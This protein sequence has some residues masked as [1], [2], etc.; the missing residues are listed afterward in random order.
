MKAN[1]LNQAFNQAQA[2]AIEKYVEASLEAL[3]PPTQ[4]IDG[5]PVVVNFAEKK[6]KPAPKAEQIPEAEDKED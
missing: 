5:G 3:M 1:Y 6:P 2:R 4:A